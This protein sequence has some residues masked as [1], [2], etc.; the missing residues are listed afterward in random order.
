MQEDPT[1]STMAGLEPM[2]KW[3]TL[4]SHPGCV[5]VTGDV[6]R[7]RRALTGLMSMPAVVAV[8]P[9]DA[10]LT[11]EAGGVA[12][13]TLVTMPPTSPSLATY[14]RVMRKE[15]GCHTPESVSTMTA[16]S[17]AE[18][19]ARLIT[20]VVHLHAHGVGLALT[21]SH[22][23]ATQRSA[24]TGVNT[25]VASLE[26][27]R[28]LEDAN[29]VAGEA[30]RRQDWE[31]VAAVVYTLTLAAYNPTITGGGVFP[32]NPRPPT[33]RKYWSAT[34][35]LAYLR[36]H[37]SGFLLLHRLVGCK[38]PA[39]TAQAEALWDPTHLWMAEIPPDYAAGC[40]YATAVTPGSEHDDDSITRFVRT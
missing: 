33:A 17:L 30:D 26:G 23:V 36:T 2:G 16:L 29:D 40:A 9:A 24:M 12:K 10:L 37:H 27:L 6:D 13:G 4:P 21:P 5:E 22:V 25:R 31:A 8:R 28:L 39:P 7:V 20:F 14:V 35:K 1:P 11:V 3:Y 18:I 32:A 38:K 15:G 19:T 34:L